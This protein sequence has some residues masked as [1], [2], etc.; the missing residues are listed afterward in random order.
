MT[1]DCSYS[2][3]SNERFGQPGYVGFPLPGVQVRLG[4]EGEIVIK[5]PGQFSGYFKQPEL[6]A[7]SFTEDGYF[8]TGDLGER[9]PNGL[10]KIAGRA[11]DLFKTTKGKYVAPAPIENRLNAHPLVELSMVSGVSQPSAYAMVVLSES[12]RPQLRNSG[13][14]TQVQAELAQLLQNVNQALPHYEQLRMIVVA[15]E[16]CTSENGLRTPTLKI[17]RSRIEAAVAVHVDG[18]FASPGL[19]HWAQ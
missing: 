10:L 16:P 6:T 14:R 9:K 7:E 1:E 11:K 3:T 17:R 19:V 4:P 12:L 8:H 5:S 2:H 13:I 15:R 18:W